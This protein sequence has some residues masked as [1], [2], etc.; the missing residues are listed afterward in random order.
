VLFVDLVGFTARSD[1]ADP[2]DVRDTL[3]LYHNRV[4]QQI[5]LYGG[6]VEK[7]IGDAVLAV[8]GAPIS[9]GDDAERAVRAGFQVLQSI[10]DLHREHPGR[11]FTVRA[12]VSTGE[13]VVTVG[14]GY[15]S[16]ETLVGDVVNTASR[17]QTAAPPGALIVDA[18]THRATR[19]AIRYEELSPIVAKGKREPLQV[20][21]AVV[22]VGE[23]AQRPVTT[24]PMVGRE[25]EMELLESIW[26]RA[27]AARRP[28]LV[29]VIGPPGIGKSRLAREMWT[30]IEDQGGRVLRGR[31]PP[32]ETRAA[33]GAFAQ[34]VKQTAGIFDSDRPEVAREKLAGAVNDLML[35]REASEMTRYL[36]LLLGL[37]LDEPVEKRVLLF[38]AARRFVESLG[39]EQPTLLV[40]EDVHWADTGELD[41]VE[42]LASNVR[43]TSMLL[44]TIARPELLE[45]RP[46]WGSGPLGQTTIALDPLSPT[47]ASAIAAHLLTNTEEGTASVERLVQISEGNPLFIEELAASVAEGAQH[48]AQLP[49]TVK[50]V[51]AS[52]LDALPPEPRA[53][54]LDASV[55]GKTFWRGALEVLRGV[56]EVDA[57]LDVLEARDL[58]RRE[59]SSQVQ[60]DAEFTFK[61]MFIRDV[62]YA[63]LPRAARRER[64]AAVARYIEGVGAAEIRELVG[65]LA[66]HWREAGDSPRAIDYLLVAAER[67]REALATEEVVDLY[68][69]ALELEEDE[70]R[71]IHIRLLLGLALVALEDFERAAT[72]L[73]ELLPQ[74]QGLDELEAVL[75]RSRATQWTERTEETLTMARRALE[76]A[77]RL[78]AKEMVGPALA[79]LSQVHAMR[80]DEGDLDRA[81]ELGDRALELWIPG[82]RPIELAEHYHMHAD[83]YYWTGGYAKA[84][85]LSRKGQEVSGD[86]ESRESLLRA[87]GMGGL[88][89]AA[90][91]RYEEAL[92]V[93]D[94]MISLGRELG[95]PVRVLLNYSTMAYRDLLDLDE[96]RARSEEALATEAA[97][98]WSSFNM[99]WMNAL[100]DLLQTD[101]LDGDIGAAEARWPSLW[102]ETRRSEAWERWYLAG[103]VAA[104][105]AE[106]ALHVDGPETAAEWATK[107][108]E[109]ARGVRRL[110]YETAAR[111]ILGRALLGMSRGAEAVAELR[112][113]VSASDRLGSPPARWQTRGALG[114]ALYQVGDD[115]GAEQAFQEAGDVIRDVAATL[116]PERAER[117]LA[118][119]PVR[120]TLAGR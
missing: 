73:D 8:F 99:P 88:T 76:L 34:Q 17:L 65:L 107:A 63:T 14:A 110:K 4:K 15:K 70:Q 67:A 56:G 16:G 46:T 81:L 23:P 39:L 18:E 12:A 92:Q 106:I 115:S 64:H 40:F 32:Y 75:A 49:A 53:A 66:H 85:E 89:L 47:E 5:E 11:G 35:E 41:L 96:A 118:A 37:G 60:G 86:P 20:W 111:T 94:E 87:G 91:G 33:F 3:D 45:M 55:I 83:N 30:V 43:D 120:E 101:L 103:K 61:H 112:T 105:R 79:R 114:R 62:A 44:M 54:L 117:L 102:E 113:A 27:M 72:E 100:V 98:G 58:I 59:R 78:D 57:A 6:T 9:H 69:A 109:M 13:A 2:E 116:S 80:G 71:R 42:Y 1:Q 74:L 119:T 51:I 95:R 97:K 7:Y 48:D 84:S 26:E 108:I 22:A 10:E 38:F 24:G 21:R 52:R 19:H 28:H 36:S 82:T 68:R 29:T 25:R 90:I 50:A 77:E 93:F 31:C 104:A